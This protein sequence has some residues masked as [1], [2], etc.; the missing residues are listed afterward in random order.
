MIYPDNFEKKIGFS[1]IRTQLKGRCMSI[2]GTEWV[3]NKV[4]FS[5]SYDEISENIALVDEFIRFMDEE[6]GVY[7]ENFFDVRQ[8]LLRIRPERTY[9]EELELFD[10]K[11]SLKTVLD[12]TQFFTK[13][14][15]AEEEELDEE[16][17]FTDASQITGGYILE[18]DK[19][20]PTTGEINYFYS[21]INNFPITIKDPDEG[22]ITSW[23]HPGFL[24]VQEHINS[25]E[26]LFEDDKYDFGRL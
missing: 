15:D 22:V 9:M 10:L 8:A 5:K 21:K 4:K 7:E 2:L 19:T 1:D 6:D 25:L 13:N 18:Y 26:Q 24:Y 14:A 23:E 12:L 16:T 11:R 20:N 17:D 3:D